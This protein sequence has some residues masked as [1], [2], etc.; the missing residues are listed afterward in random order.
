MDTDGFED[1][2]CTVTPQGGYPHLGKDLQQSLIYGIDIILFSFLIIL[3]NHFFI[4]QLLNDRETEVRIY[5]GSTVAKQKGK[6]M[7]LS[8]VT[9][10]HHQVDLH[11]F[12]C[13][14]KVVVNGR[15][16]QQ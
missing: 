15:Y 3:L 9:G 11:P 5:N 2:G 6:M 4:Y 14:D 12:P 8:G 7:Y 10:F 13:F 16:G 1:L